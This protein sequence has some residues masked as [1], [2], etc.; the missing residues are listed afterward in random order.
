MEWLIAIWLVLILPVGIAA[1]YSKSLKQPGSDDS[2][3]LAIVSIIAVG[4]PIFI[5]F[6]L[7]FLGINRTADKVQKR[8]A[9]K[10]GAFITRVM[11]KNN[12][13]K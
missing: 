10:D 6:Y 8:R 11:N 2:A 4:W 3:W 1:A 12:L 9:E 7:G 13:P 5:F